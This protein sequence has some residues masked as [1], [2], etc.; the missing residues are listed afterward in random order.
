MNSFLLF[1]FWWESKVLS[2]FNYKNTTVRTELQEISPGWITNG[3]KPCNLHPKPLPV[4]LSPQ[5]P[6]D[7]GPHLRF[8][9]KFHLKTE[10]GVHQELTSSIWA[11][12]DE[13]Y[14]SCGFCSKSCRIKTPS[15]LQSFSLRTTFPAVN[16]PWSQLNT[17]K[18]LR[19]QTFLCYY[20]T[21]LGVKV[22]K[23][24][25]ATLTFPSYPGL[26]W[27]RAKRLQGWDELTLGLLL[28]QCN[29]PSSVI[30]AQETPAM[31]SQQ[32]WRSLLGC[33]I[34]RKFNVCSHCIYLQWMLCSK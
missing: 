19:N 8:H 13:I 3:V 33:V 32:S 10:L 21:F 24:P 17:P 14:P 26:M 34:R 5:W 23:P 6:P 9:L 31:R 1:I 12:R 30:S 4:M 27:E 25:Q 16:V 18:L 20:Y 15:S 29:S 7:L 28:S 2:I 22:T 11:K